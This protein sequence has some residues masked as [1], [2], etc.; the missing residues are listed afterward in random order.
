MSSGG[1]IGGDGIYAVDTSVLI[2]SLRGDSGIRN[3]LAATTA[4]YIPCIALGE[5]Y[6]GAYG[7]PTRADAAVRDIVALATT[8]AVLGVDAVTAQIYGRIKQELKGRGL[9]MPGNDLWIAATAIQYDVTL[10]AR[11]AH[12]EWIK[13]LRSEQ[14]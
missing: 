5:L 6:Q 11:D 9:L 14:W 1:L 4:L 8:N 3:R 13:G 2:L 10:A 12:F 7:S